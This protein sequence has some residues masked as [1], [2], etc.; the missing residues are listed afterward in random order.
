MDL[1]EKIAKIAEDN[2]LDDSLFLVEVNISAGSVPKVE[3]LIDGDK[4][5]DIS[6]CAKLSRKIGGV[7]EETEMIE[8]AYNLEVSSPGVG[9]PLKLLRQY[10]A[11]IGRELK[12]LLNEGGELNGK[13]KE[14]GENDVL[15][16]VETRVKKHKK[17]IEEKRIV[18]SDIKQ[19][20]VQ[21]SF[22]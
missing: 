18:F 3:V 12:V 8:G 22:K 7:V 5:V 14:V 15:L 10:R 6:V 21:V 13:L 17:E 16:E 2:L 1:E 19:A 9:Q 11:N 20:K 4:G